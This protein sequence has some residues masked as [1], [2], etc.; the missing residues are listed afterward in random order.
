LNKDKENFGDINQKKKEQLV[1]KSSHKNGMTLYSL[2][3]KTQMKKKK[4]KQ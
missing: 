1:R 4:E 2:K 3:K